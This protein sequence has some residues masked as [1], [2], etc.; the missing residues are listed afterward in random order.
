MC[1]YKYDSENTYTKSA[2]FKLFDKK[3][4]TSKYILR[5]SWW[6][7]KTATKWSLLT[8][9]ICLVCISIVWS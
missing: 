7:T 2:I 1:C 5:R 9:Q 3:T 8:F 6:K 4:T